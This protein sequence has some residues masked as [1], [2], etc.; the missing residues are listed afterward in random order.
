MI[1]QMCSDDTGGNRFAGH[2]GTWGL[3]IFDA[4]RRIVGR[5]SRRQTAYPVPRLAVARNS[6]RMPWTAWFM[7]PDFERPSGGIRKLYGSV[8]ILN[9]A[10]LEAA[11]VHQRRG[12]RCTWF[13][14]RTRIVSNKRTAV[15][16]QDVIVVPKIYGRS[17]RDLP[18]GVR[19]VIFN[20]NAYLTLNSLVRD[21]AAAAPYIDNPD[22]STVLVVSEDSARLVEYAFPGIRVQRVRP[23]LDPVLYHPA[24]RPKT[25]PHRLYAKKAGA[26]GCSGA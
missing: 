19:Q 10:G 17:I 13:E 4:T 21:R 23:G 6:T 15:R 7:C 1:G 2:P 26:R 3:S 14:H 8:D 9:D 5:I 25:S 22:L 18:Q 20:Q 24:K 16:Q 12:F 11:I